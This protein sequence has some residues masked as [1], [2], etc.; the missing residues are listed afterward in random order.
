MSET[1][2]TLTRLAI[3]AGMILFGLWLSR[4]KVQRRRHVDHGEWAQ[5]SLEERFR[6]AVREP[7]LADMMVVYGAFSEVNQIYSAIQAPVAPLPITG[8][9]ANSDSAQVGAC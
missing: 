7:G 3:V 6:D 5:K 4:A 9:V 2:F 8:V 1:A